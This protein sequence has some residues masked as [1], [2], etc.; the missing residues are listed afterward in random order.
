MQLVALSSLIDKENPGAIEHH[1]FIR[2]VLDLFKTSLSHA[3][4]VVGDSCDTY[5]AT[6]DMR[7]VLLAGCASHRFNL[8]VKKVLNEKGQLLMG[9]DI[10]LM[11][12]ESLILAYRLCKLTPS[13]ARAR[14]DTI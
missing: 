2:H 3:V 4:R 12:L 8:A 1:E 9:L 10:L 5:D 13:T 11:K 14:N 6:I 7:S